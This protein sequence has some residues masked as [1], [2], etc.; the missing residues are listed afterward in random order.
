MVARDLHDVL[1]ILY[2]AGA[3][4]VPASDVEWSSEMTPA[5]NRAISMQYIVYQENSKGRRF[6]LSEAGYIAIG[7]QPP[8]Y[9]SIS[10]TLRSLLGLNR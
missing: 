1:T 6:S 2:E 8:N 10:R 9:M 3:T 5:L 4:R 7:K